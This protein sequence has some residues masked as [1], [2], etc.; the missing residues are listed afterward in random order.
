MSCYAFPAKETGRRSLLWCQH[1][2]RSSL[3]IARVGCCLRDWAAIFGSGISTSLVMIDDPW[4]PHFARNQV[5]QRYPAQPSRLSD[6]P[7]P[8][9]E[10]SIAVA[11]TCNP[12]HAC[13]A[14][15]VPPALG[16]PA[17][18]RRE[19]FDSSFRDVGCSILFPRTHCP[20]PPLTGPRRVIHHTVC[21]GVRG[22]AFPAATAS[23]AVPVT[24]RCC[25]RRRAC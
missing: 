12:P 18:Y 23:P 3:E 13:A 24:D 4:L 1:R 20:P 22:G 17:S 11:V 21:V 15:R 9:R 16:S 19:V 8:C 6:S 10:F 2:R 25:N 14:R 7:R 5:P